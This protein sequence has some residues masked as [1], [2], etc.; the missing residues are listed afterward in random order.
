MKY[1]KKLSTNIFYNVIRIFLVTLLPII[2]F[3]FNMKSRYKLSIINFLKS[4]I[5][6]IKKPEYFNVNIKI[7]SWVIKSWKRKE[8]DYGRGFLYQSYENFGLYGLRAT[9]HK[10]QMINKLLDLGNKKILDIGS[11]SGFLSVEV[12]KQAKF[13][14]CVEPNKYLVK[15]GGVLSDFLNQKNII[16]YIKKFEEFKTNEKF[17]AVLSFANHSTYDGETEYTL[18]EYFSKI[19][20]LLEENGN[21][22]FESHHPYIEKDLSKVKDILLRYFDIKDEMLLESNN[23]IDNGRTWLLCQKKLKN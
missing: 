18:E 22:V 2:F 13:V 3:L 17:G 19:S 4:Y 5:F 9:N 23:F 21:L 16:F 15:Q 7:F 6:L 12:A 8:L 1:I 20:L 10:M 14:S 11:N